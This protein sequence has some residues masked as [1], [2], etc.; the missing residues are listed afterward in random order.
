MHIR[1]PLTPL[2]ALSRLKL[3]DFRG[4]HVDKPAASY[5]TDEKCTT[6]EYLSKLSKALKRKN[7]QH[8]LF[9]DVPP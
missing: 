7:P 5:W 6:M 3:L 8:R 4:V 2:A 9:F 1:A